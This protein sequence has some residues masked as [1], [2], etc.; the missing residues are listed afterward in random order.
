MMV[1]YLNIG[2]AILALVA[3]VLWFLSARV[4]L[5]PDAFA[6]VWDG[7][8]KS[9]RSWAERSS[10]WNRFAALISGF[11]ALCFGIASL[12]SGGSTS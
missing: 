2:G 11:S 6:T 5:P 3:S 8:G 9:E 4:K 12:V 10:F 7:T 1:Q